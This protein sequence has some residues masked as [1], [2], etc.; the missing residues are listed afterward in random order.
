MDVCAKLEHGVYRAFAMGAFVQSHPFRVKAG[1]VKLVPTWSWR[2]YWWLLNF[3][4]MLSYYV[5]L[6]V[7]F[8]LRLLAAFE[9]T[10]VMVNLLISAF[11]SL[12]FLSQAM[13]WVNKDI[14]PQLIASVFKWH[15]SFEAKYKFSNKNQALARNLK[16][17]TKPKWIRIGELLHPVILLMFTVYGI[18]STRGI[19]FTKGIDSLFDVVDWL[20]P[21]A[22]TCA[23]V[24]A[25][26]VLHAYIALNVAS[27]MV[28]FATTG[29][30]A[31]VTYLA[32][33]DSMRLL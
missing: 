3:F 17:T 4:S 26:S 15:R 27:L 32:E 18:M 8:G 9:L 12:I 6:N 13:M 22:P 20:V 25:I 31:A 19:V 5:Y 28:L 14:L 24:A 11:F 16:S 1:K 21:D 29:V 33:L 7:R 2:Y 10:S 30:A 23:K